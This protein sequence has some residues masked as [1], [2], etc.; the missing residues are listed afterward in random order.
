MK[1]ISF[2]LVA[3]TAAGTGLLG[4]SSSSGGESGESLSPGAHPDAGASD[5][6][7]PTAETFDCL[8]NAEWTQV[9]ASVYKNVLGHTAEMLAVA[10]S[11]D[12]G[13]FPEGTVVQLVPYEAN[14]KRA[15]G[16]SP[17]SHDW[18]F[19]S[20][21]VAAS[22]TTIKTSGGNAQVLSMFGGGSCLS[23]HTMAAPQWDLVCGDEDG[24]NT[25]GCQSLPFSG[26]QLAMTRA[27][28][29]RCK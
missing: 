1:Q 29:P 22:G 8:K 27:T 21:N 20:L 15:P 18:E 11:P 17:A 25:H 9:G 4:C 26:D 24:G 12:G 2:L 7:V 3:M 28:D 19:F 14:V 16:Y 6:F 13:V 10:N 5:V 23:C